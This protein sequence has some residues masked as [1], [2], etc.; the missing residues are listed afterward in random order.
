MTATP[1]G[2]TPTSILVVDDMPENIDIL[3]RLLTNRGYTVR[4]ALDG[5]LAL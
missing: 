2:L 5:E 3:A 1:S 4:R